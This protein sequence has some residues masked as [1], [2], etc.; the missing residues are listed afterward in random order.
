MKS[1]WKIEK[2][3]SVYNRDT[4]TSELSLLILIVYHT[5]PRPTV[6]LYREVYAIA[7]DFMGTIK[8][9]NQRLYRTLSNYIYRSFMEPS[10]SLI[11][12]I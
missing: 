7:H 2:S 5:E 8:L 9:V 12:H 3:I 1:T 4:V 11:T 10:I 6:N